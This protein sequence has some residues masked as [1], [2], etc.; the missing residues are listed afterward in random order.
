M[1]HHARVSYFNRIS[2]QLHDAT[3][4]TRKQGDTFGRII[5]KASTKQMTVS[6]AE[7]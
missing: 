6:H 2:A 3:I 7:L 1:L 4:R 5:A